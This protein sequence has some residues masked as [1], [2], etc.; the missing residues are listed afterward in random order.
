M[1]I[2]KIRGSYGADAQFLNPA[3]NTV[4]LPEQI[5]NTNPE[6]TGIYLEMILTLGIQ[7]PTSSFGFPTKFRPP[8]I[9]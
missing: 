9:Y 4:L 8:R 7:S 2:I 1:K 3:T 5:Q 6:K